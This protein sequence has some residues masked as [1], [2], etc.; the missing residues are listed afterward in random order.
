MEAGLGRFRSKFALLCYAVI[1]RSM[2][3]CPFAMEFL[4]ASCLSWGVNYD[5]MLCVY[6]RFV[7]WK[8]LDK[9]GTLQSTIGNLE[10]HMA[11]ISEQTD[12]CGASCSKFQVSTT[13]LAGYIAFLVSLLC[14]YVQQYFDHSC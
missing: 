12:L 9:F 4:I 11:S 3:V 1:P 10:C 14:C 5:V 2:L 6:T 13:F 8:T 7:I